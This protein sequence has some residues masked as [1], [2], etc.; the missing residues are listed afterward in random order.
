MGF[1]YEK[2]VSN[3]FVRN[4]EGCKVGLEAC[5]IAIVSP[6]AIMP[7]KLPCIFCVILKM[8]QPYCFSTILALDASPSIILNF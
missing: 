1:I 5:V 7:L 4:D 2:L 3:N 8:L 6:Y